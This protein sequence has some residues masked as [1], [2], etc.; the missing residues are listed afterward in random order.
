MIPVQLPLHEPYFDL[1][2][3]RT[4]HRKKPIKMSKPYRLVNQNKRANL[5]YRFLSACDE[6]LVPIRSYIHRDMVI[7][8]YQQFLIHAAEFQATI[9]FYILSYFMRL[10]Q[11]RIFASLCL[12]ICGTSIAHN[13]K[14]M[15]TCLSPC[16]L[17]QS[18]GELLYVK[19]K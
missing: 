7:H 1:T 14:A 17:I 16:Y 9:H 4:I 3:I 19:I 15:M 11:T 6:W 5:L 18:S 10:A 2:L 12:G 13:I 8:D